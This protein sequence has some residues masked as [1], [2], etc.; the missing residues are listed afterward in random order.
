MLTKPIRL[1]KITVRCQPKKSITSIT[2][3]N[4]DLFIFN[5]II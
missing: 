4:A 2:Q 5:L 1:G 3:I